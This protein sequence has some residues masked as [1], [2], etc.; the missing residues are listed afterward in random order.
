MF[1]LA[2]LRHI[3]CTTENHTLARLVGDEGAF[4]GHLAPLSGAAA[5][6]YMRST[7]GFLTAGQFPLGKVRMLGRMAA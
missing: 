5:G 7:L 1:Y 2:L 3:G 6:E 4:G